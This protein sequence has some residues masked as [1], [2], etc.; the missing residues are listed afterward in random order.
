MISGRI[1]RPAEFVVI[2]NRNL[3]DLSTPSAQTLFRDKR[4]AAC[5]QRKDIRS[6]VSLLK[7]DD[8]EMSVLCLRQASQKLMSKHY[9]AIKMAK[10]S[11]QAS[12]EEK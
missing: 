3:E 4:T 1:I 7:K 10:Q 8:I 5:S 9:C 2:R 12:Q 6:L 11:D